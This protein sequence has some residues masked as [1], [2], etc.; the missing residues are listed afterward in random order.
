MR[1]RCDRA[2]AISRRPNS[3]RPHGRRVCQLDARVLTPRYP[4]GMPHLAIIEP[5]DATGALAEVY[6]KMKARKM[7]P[8]CAS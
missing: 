5:A 3:A 4:R 6:A 2:R 8:W 7:P 1:L